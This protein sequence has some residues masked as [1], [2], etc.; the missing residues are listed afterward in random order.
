MSADEAA[1]AIL[2]RMDKGCP[3]CGVKGR[4]NAGW[5]RYSCVTPTCRVL[6]FNPF[7][8]DWNC[9]E[10]GHHPVGQCPFDHPFCKQAGETHE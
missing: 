10:G 2:E 4:E 1:M 3:G 7:A 8:A 9:P 5:V 6:F